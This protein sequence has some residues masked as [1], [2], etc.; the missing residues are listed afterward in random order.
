MNALGT[1]TATVRNNRGTRLRSARLG[2]RLAGIP[3]MEEEGDKHSPVPSRA[4]LTKQEAA[5][6]DTALSVFIADTPQAVRGHLSAGNPSACNTRTVEAEMAEGMRR[7]VTE[8]FGNL[9]T[10]PGPNLGFD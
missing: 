2:V 5:T 10:K 6:L 4:R 3:Y 7:N 1:L 8:E 9:P